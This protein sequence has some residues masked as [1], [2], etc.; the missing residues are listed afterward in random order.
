[1]PFGAQL[2]PTG[3]VRF[4]LWAPG[5]RR[6][7]LRL[8]GPAEELLAMTPMPGGWFEAITPDASAGTRYRFRPDDGP[9]LPDPASRCNPDDVHA[10]SRVV[11][12]AAYAWQDGDW[13]G[14]P[15]EDTVL[16]ELHVGTFTPA[17][18]FRAAM[19]R[20]D[21]LVELGI[22]AVELMPVANFPG[23]R[24]WGYDGVLAFAPDAAYGTPDDLKA[25]VD[26]A[27]AR[28]L[29]VFLDVVYNHFGPEGNY[30]HLYAEP[31]FSAR[32]HTPWGAAINFDGAGSRT[33]RDFFIANALHWLT[34]YHI[35]GLR[36]DA[37]D[38]ILDDSGRHILVELAEA[39]RAGPGREQAIHLVLENDLNQARFLERD[40]ATPRWHTAQW[41]DDFCHAMHV[42]LT[43]ERDGY[44]ADCAD[45]P[46]EHLGRCLAE[47]FAWQGEPSAYRGGRARGEPSGHLPAG[48]FVAFIQNHD[49]VGN[50]AFGE[51][52]GRLARPEA[53]RA[54]S[55]V[56]L[57]AP[58]VP[59]LFMG[60]E[61]AA[62][63][64]FL[65][66]CD[67]EPGLRDAV[68]DGRRRE[69]ARF[70]RF[71]DPALRERIPD[72]CA[73]ETFAAS[74]LDWRSLEQPEHAA[75][76]AFH[77][78]LLEVRRREIVPRLAG[79]RGLGY[80]VVAGQAGGDGECDGG[81]L[82]P[83]PS[84]GGGR[85]PFP[86]P[87]HQPALTVT[88]RLADG[89]R[90]HLLANLAD[91]PLAGIPLPAGRTLFRLPE[92]L[93]LAGTA[94]TLPPWGLAWRLEAPP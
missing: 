43:G 40:G 87:S 94:V 80:R 5:A 92:D 70:A 86:S 65:F 6:V 63:T 12:P 31:F 89:S 78:S 48:A 47:G 81:S 44:Y 82:I 2:L 39:V 9:W 83:S 60:Q 77:R 54:A 32:H 71:A 19:E 18:T 15:W 29:M 21:Y 76:L 85:E 27:H 17:G 34:E 90:L 14:R 56:L 58:M 61:F 93:D 33:V 36:L 62:A 4:R 75:W 74:R 73:V 22:T 10:A 30:L 50:R 59:L 53:L 69:F 35:D 72:P 37:V 16:Y 49:Q 52:L 25:L 13:R 8:E 7:E 11:D 28:G 41:D 88:W 51:R 24:N 64:P 91:C 55:A 66:F 79:V 46:L 1:M 84:P 3:G 42:L 20:L 26:A 68:R 57:L 45:A 38:T 67:F 23:R